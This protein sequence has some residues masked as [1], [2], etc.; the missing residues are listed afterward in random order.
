MVSQF[1]VISPLGSYITCAVLHVPLE[2]HSTVSRAL[3]QPQYSR[4]SSRH[5]TSSL[6]IAIMLPKSIFAFA[7]L[8]VAAAALPNGQTTT[9]STSASTSH[10]STTTSSTSTAASAIPTVNNGQTFVNQCNNTGLSIADC[11]SLL[12]IALLNGATIVVGSGSPSS[13]AVNNGQEF[14]NQC[15]NFGVSVLDCAQL[16]NIA[17]FNGLNIDISL[18]ALTSL[19]SALGLPTGL[20]AL[21]GSGSKLI[22]LPLGS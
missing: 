14:L 1:V 10:A 9:K 16:L 19:L 7:T 11:T 8:L 22:S 17:A 5:C 21:L 15:S 4:Y 18:S 12:N 2:L 13:G 6:T 20:L 3:R